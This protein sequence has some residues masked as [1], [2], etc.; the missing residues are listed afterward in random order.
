MIGF[1]SNVESW[2]CNCVKA[3]I[4]LVRQIQGLFQQNL[5]MKK[6]L[7]FI[8]HS[9]CTHI[10]LHKTTCW[11]AVS[12]GEQFLQHDEY[13]CLKSSFLAVWNPSQKIYDLFNI[14]PQQKQLI[15][16]LI[17]VPK[18]LNSSFQS[19]VKELTLWH[20]VN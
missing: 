9:C 20:S 2:Y 15:F 1:Y 19:I 5:A 13:T 8:T 12:T 3:M 11:L 6:L 7:L 17:Y 14:L 18:C 10:S 4:H 16:G